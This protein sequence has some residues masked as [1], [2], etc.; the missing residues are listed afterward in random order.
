MAS[1]GSFVVRLA[2][3][4]IGIL[5]I[6]VATTAGKDDVPE[7]KPVNDRKFHER[8]LTIARIYPTYGRVDDEARWGPLLCRRPALPGRAHASQSEDESTHGRKLYSLF[9]RD[10]QAYVQPDRPTTVP[11]D[12]V[13]QVIV[14][15][16]WVPEEMKERPA[17]LGRNP[18]GTGR[19]TKLG[20][21]DVPKELASVRPVERSEDYFDPYVEKDGKLFK[22]SK[23]ADLF[24]MFRLADPKTDGTDEG[25]VYGTVTPDGKTVTSA[26]RV[27]SCMKCHET[28]KS[29]LFGIK[30]GAGKGE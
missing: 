17:D 5:S 11:S 13:Q 27:A 15:E 6:V 3:P 7:A 4:V 22:A 29:R 26:G 16:S 24:I 23:K 19:A 20:K 21:T 25:W 2:L 8:L 28:K 1:W 10:R 14:K 30:A 12:V 9:A 18:L